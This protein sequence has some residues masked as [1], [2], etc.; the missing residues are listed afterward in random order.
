LGVEATSAG[1]IEI[2]NPSAAATFAIVRKLGLPSGANARESPARVIPVSRASWLSL[3]ARAMAP[4][5]CEM[6]AGSPPLALLG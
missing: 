6:R 1:V 3:R 5:A 2:F 4:S